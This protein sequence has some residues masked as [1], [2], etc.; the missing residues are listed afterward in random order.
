[1]TVELKIQFVFTKFVTSYFT[2]RTLDYMRKFYLL[3]TL[4]LTILCG[5]MSYAQD[6]SNKGKDFWVAYG[7][8]QIMNAGN[9]QEMILYFSAEQVTNV[10]VSIPALAYV[11]NYTIPANT[12][13]ASLPLP[14]TGLQDC[15]LTAESSSPENKGIHI[16]SDKAIVAY[17]HIYNGSVSGATILFPT[18]TL[19]KEY[20]SV[21]YTNTSNSNNA[22][23][24][25][26]VMA[27]DT[28]TTT[29]EI[30]P[31][32]N[33]IN[34]PAGTTF[35]I[36]LTQGQV[37]NL[38]GQLTTSSN[39]FQ[40]V[41][42]SGTKIQS[43]ASATGGCKRIAVFSGSGRIS[44]TC[45]GTS[46]S[47]DNYIVQAFPKSAWGKKYLTVPSVSYNVV[48]GNT[49]SLSAP[50][51]YRINVSDP[52]TVVTINGVVTA[53]P[54]INNFYYEVAAT[55]AP[56]LIEADK[57]VVVS[58]YFP[59][60]VNCGLPAPAGDGDP[61]VIYLSSVEQNINKVLWNAAAKF[62]IN[63]QKHYINAVIRNTGTA[64]SSFRLDGVPVPAS[65]FV[66]H[67]QDPGYSYVRL[68]VASNSGPAGF[69]GLPHIIQ[70][71]SGFNAIAY[72][73]GSAESYGYNAGTNIKD[74][75]QYVSVQNQYGTVNFPATCKNTPFYFSMTFP[76]QPTSI[77]WQFNGLFPDFN[78][79]DPSLY[80]IGTIVVGG[81]TLYQYRIPTPYTIPTAGTY[82]I[83][84]IATNPTPDGCGGIQEIDY[85]VQ[86]FNNPV[87]DFNF[88]N[89]CFPDP[90]Q[91][92]DNSNT[93]GRPV[94][95]R[96]W[97]F[98]DAATSGI[99]NPSHAYAAPGTYTVRYS[100]I[101]DI[102][103]IADTVQH[104]VTV[105]PLPT[106]SISGNNEVCLNTTPLPD[107]TFTGA[108]GMAP[109]TFTYNI[110]GGPNQVVTTTVGNSVTVPAPTGVAGTFVYNLVSV[111][112]A[113]PAICSQAQTGSVTIIVNPLPTASVTG[114]TAVCINSPSPNVTFTGAVGTAPYTF[115]YNINGGP[116]Q[117]ITTTVG[118]SV[119]IAAPTGVAGTFVYNLLSVQ[120][121][122]TTLCNQAQ[123][124]SA[125][126]TI[127]PDAA[128]SL[129][130]GSSTQSLCINTPIANISYTITGGGTGGTVSGLP[131][132]VTGSYSAGVF[133][134]AG[135]PT[136]TGVYNYTVNTTGTC[137]QTT[138]SGTIT[139]NPDATILLSSAAAT[140]NQ[141]LCINV[142]IANITYAI[143]GGGTGGT[144]SG[145]PPGVNGVYSAGVLTISGSPTT[146]GTYN[147]TVNTTGTCLQTAASGTITVNPDADI[148]LTSVAGTTNQELCINSTITNITYTISGGGTGGTVS[149]L[150]AGVTG[151]FSGGV[152]TI[153]GTPTV[154]GTFNYTVTTTGT[155]VQK[156]A[157]GTILVN[158]LP[159]PD[160]SVTAPTCETKVLTF[161][162]LSTPN[163]G[164]LN[165][166]TWNFGDAGTSTLQNPVH[167][168]AA[169]GTY[170]VTLS[171]TTDKG[172]VSN[173]ILTRSVTVNP[174][175]D[176][177]FILPEVCLSDTY[178]QFT[179]TSDVAS[180][181]IVSWLWD[182]GDPG[183]GPLNTS[184]L[185]NP[186]H[187]YTA[188]GNYTVTL[189]VTTN[190]GCVATRSSSFTVN[191]DI[192]V[193]NFNAL[194]PATMCANDSIAIQD[195][196]TV[197]FGSVTK[198]EIYWDNVNFPA[199]FQ[200]DDFP[201]PG[202]IYRHL[203]PNFQA[204]LTRTFTVRYRAYSGA[205]CVNDRIKT[206]VVNAAPK[207]QFNNMP[208]ACL[209]AA[210]FQITQA[211]EIGAVPGTG[212]F[213]G[214]GVNATG[215]FNP[216]LVGPGTYT[217]KYTFTSTAGG[218]I[219]SLSKTITVLD[220]ASAQFTF[221][222][223][224]CENGPVSFNST[225]STIP[226]ASGTITGWTWN[227]GDPAS[228][229]NNTSTLQNPTHL[230]SGWGTY[231]VTLS[232]TTSNGCRSTVRTIP[233]F[234]NP[235]PRPDFSFPASSCL[236]SA[237][238][239]FN[240]S[241]SSIPDG[242]QSSFTYL[243]DFGDPASGPLNTSTGSSPSHIY[244]S[245]GPFTVTL[246][247]T[248]GAGCVNT[249]TIIVNTIHPQP[250]G[251]FTTNKDDVCVGQSFTFTDNSNPADGTTQQWNW[252]MGD[253]N[254]R[255]S[256]S[257]N[258][259]YGTAGSYDVSLFITNN[260]GCRSTTFTKTVTVNPYPI[261]NAGPDL[262]IL[263]D[264]SDTIQP[265][266]TAINPT[267]LWTPNLYFLSSN[268][269]LNPIV[270]GVDDITY[271]L[272]VTG[273]G[274][275][276]STDQVFIK[277]LK[278]PE[279]P[280]IFSPNGDGIHDKWE[281]KYLDTYPGGTVEIFNRY[282]QLI[283]RSVGYGQPWD[284]TI[285]G[286]QVPIGTYY[287]I[288][289]PK[290]GRKIMSGY[291]DV[292]R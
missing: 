56:M 32:A 252:T 81:K 34:H 7:Y 78:M 264:G 48:A 178:A 217:I 171:V 117:F 183:S 198:V 288:V 246:Q 140:T 254:T 225:S 79:P 272:T 1:M 44:I 74:I 216:A 167:T 227:F 125:T 94:I 149:G 269:I 275:C 187:S 263:Q 92:T 11:Q 261:V 157:T 85:E 265:I 41:D 170:T 286:K 43:I 194:N 244:N 82:P 124:G 289:D 291:V 19:G 4:V 73:Y 8:H 17:A 37:Y 153:S 224:N 109:Y 148:V 77:V 100:L 247:I 70:S 138:A 262:F 59:S 107:V 213:S 137:L 76:Y 273:R 110:N 61:E 106:A 258:Y 163:A 128:I 161:T 72:G 215:I 144:V 145:L 232:V 16:T 237:T 243:W 69:V 220:S 203:Y 113:S 66:T 168:Y 160:F 212:V 131:P 207:V 201:T 30:T 150:P 226:V 96:H 209:D 99:N 228:G 259:T 176:P 240:S 103:C 143:G 251:S 5:S 2:F 97:N 180:G 276:I 206:I 132:G 165:G 6:F 177:G 188:V 230:F 162:D 136:A 155:C 116:N 21:N 135:T 121:A 40:G 115:T 112:D 120:D 166:W 28:G 18:N 184:I 39:P 63:Q 231:N 270:K 13:I 191:G 287:Y 86:V 159:T 260:H 93:D 58:Q 26:Y 279:I 95:S 10:T 255:T 141:T 268:T 87:A 9:G 257:F 195:A 64:I 45:N 253:G 164:V 193:S 47:S 57:P 214:P 52:T 197:N 118:S 248:S 98:G 235:L 108:V 241:A 31:S 111:A 282:G 271:T 68:N 186:Q 104:D 90:V 3:S 88:N 210:P 290:N 274:G 250:T 36:T 172:C 236:P 196:S 267:Y 175:P 51:I 146:I 130:A 89:V 24:W 242:T 147:Y 182:F 222:T 127:D 292:I 280:N 277:V 218:C 62:D 46:S 38:M 233:V 174:Q 29:V 229:V 102:G 266:V 139:V 84:V 173:P 284:G 14:K 50:N 205:T 126:I 71:D 239:A 245:V 15:R 199:V 91:F 238:V 134:I 158:P 219:D 75:F 202:K 133:T 101:T 208:D 185:Q 60:R 200:T 223:L 152:F 256:S 25:V 154:S 55:A 169:A 65:S 151:V 123:T 221:S 12:T 281:I 181:S 122:T 142:A 105:S 249:K 234:V 190:N 42:L 23:S 27:A 53:L 33:T 211:S 54:L 283:F 189:T 49:T 285:N 67:P 179:D 204:P 80:F 114:T 278:G 83:K 192:P 22:N 20:Y 35:T 156:T 129:T 119:T